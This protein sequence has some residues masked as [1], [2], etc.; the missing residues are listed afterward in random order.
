MG[1]RGRFGRVAWSVLALVTMASCDTSLDTAGSSDPL[2]A[3]T[4]TNTQDDDAGATTAPDPITT[5]KAGVIQ[6]TR[7]LSGAGSV[8]AESAAIAVPAGALRAATDLTVAAIAEESIAADLSSVLTPVSPATA[9]TPHGTTFEAP[10]TLSLFYDAPAGAALV[11]LRLDDE[12]DT[13]WERVPA[14]FKDG[15]AFFETTHFSI[16]SVRGCDP[17]E[18]TTGICK[19]VAE[20]T[21]DL[22][23]LSAAAVEDAAVAADAGVGLPEDEATPRDA[24]MDAEVAPE[25]SKDGGTTAPVTWDAGAADAGPDAGEIGCDWTER[26][27][28]EVRCAAPTGADGSVGEPVKADGSCPAGTVRAVTKRCE[29]VQTCTAA[30]CSLHPDVCGVS[31]A[32]SGAAA[33]GGTTAPDCHYEKLCSTQMVCPGPTASSD[34]DMTKPLGDAAATADGGAESGDAGI[35]TDAGAVDGGVCKPVERCEASAC[36]LPPECSQVCKDVQRCD[37]KGA[38]TSELLCE[39]G[40]HANSACPPPVCT[41]VEECASSV[42]CNAAEM[43][44]VELCQ[45]VYVC[46]AYDAGTR[47][48]ADASATVPVK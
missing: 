27:K 44:P 19:G 32:G 33:D 35:P 14:I 41:I 43:L 15:V 45:Q 1:V 12:Q 26:C 25:P 23:D 7:T 30:Y 46:G 13:T 24:A 21:T 20:G 2:D 29:P 11:V 18:D 47:G 28:E 3:G 39:T 31:D 37:A 17:A 40:C 4:G 42:P 8:I 48:D 10:V 6:A 5:P 22:E 34:G 36:D 38:C 16:Y 9:F